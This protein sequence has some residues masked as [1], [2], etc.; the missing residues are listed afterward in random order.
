MTTNVGVG[1]L[2]N[3]DGEQ[4]VKIGDYPYKLDVASPAIP[5]VWPG[6]SRM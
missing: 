5:K 1:K 3:A 4:W 6:N 2:P